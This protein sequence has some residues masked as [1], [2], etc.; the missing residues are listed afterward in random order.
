ME[1]IDYLNQ[2]FL[3][4]DQLLQASS[5]DAARLD[6]LSR[7]GAMPQ[8]SYRLRVTLGCDSYFGTYMEENAIDYYAR[9]YVEWIG[10]LETTTAEPFA[11]FAQ[12][13]RAALAAL[14]L[15]CADPMLNANLEAH[16]EQEWRHFRDGTYGLCTRSGL[17]ED[18]AA[19]ALSV[20]VIRESTRPDAPPACLVRLREAV[21]LL[22]RAS[23]PF[24]PH[25]R[26][27]SSRH[28]YV[29]DIRKRYGL[30]AKH[31]CEQ[32]PCGEYY[33]PSFAWTRA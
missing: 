11:V 33:S 10:L 29:D 3:T 14:P 15:R 4:R 1:L 22:D 12:R 31:H 23:S 28:R 9:G 17:P 2:H 24:A 5:I 20:C 13:Y 19:K 21:D 30:D 26:L 7:S 25:E 32:A 16:L 6:V 27:R 18:I 8:P